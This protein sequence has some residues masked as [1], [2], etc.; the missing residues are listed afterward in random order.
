MNSLQT[1]FAP[2]RHRSWNLWRNPIFRRY[3]QSRLRVH[4]LSVTL[5]LTIL[6]AGFI[7]GMSH[8]I[9]VQQNERAEDLARG[10][11]I[12][13]LVV[14]GLILFV[15]GT[16]QVA[17]GMTA[18]RDE[19][20]ID[21]QRLVPMSPLAK[22]VGYLFGL[23]VREYVM[24]FTTLPFSA[25]LA[26]RGNI[27]METW[28]PLYTVFF[29][30]TLLYHFTGLLT[31]TVAKN[32]R[33]AFL[34]SIGLVF[35]L[36]TVVPYLSKFGLVFFKY[37]TIRPVFE[38]LLPGML[39]RD[40]G[41]MVEAGQRLVPTVKF[42][43]LDFSEMVF[44]V[45][46]QGGLI[47][48]FIV[49]LCRKW[50]RHES[51]LLGKL[52]AAGFFIW[53]QVLL[54]GNAL[55]LIDPGTLFPTREFTR[56]ARMLLTW[57]PKPE[58]ALA[59]SALYGLATM[60]LLFILAAIISPTPESQIRGWRRARKQGNRSLPMLSDA[61]T[62]FWSVAVMALAGAGGWYLFSRGLV[63]SRWFDGHVLPLSVFGYF[64]AILLAAGLG[65]QIL[66]ETKGGRAVVLAAIFVGVV[67]MMIGAL[68]AAMGSKL[69]PVATWFIGMSP[70]SMPT[71]A[72]G[73]LLPMVE[74]PEQVVRAIPRA[75]K[76]WLFVSVIGALWLIVR[77]WTTRKAMAA[78]VLSAP[79]EQA[80]PTGP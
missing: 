46:S 43:G 37:L 4:G 74:L 20:V 79:A 34:A 33:W 1:S 32:R 52:W 16:A 73:S 26:W 40:V 68:L 17:G 77:L 42:F 62:G 29:T 10:A 13:M 21:Y 12:A 55:P 53:I 31:G 44:T 48:T 75:F 35:A 14:Q 9:A 76:F 72:A 70:L 24:F 63:E 71:Y 39:P 2:I 22:V 38:E 41:A 65:F 18:E 58:E 11:F 51:H 61:S 57:S 36:Y 7:A 27:A 49:M 30:S 19:G 6:V 60:L 78:D 5:L 54:L 3:C 80:P 67:P 23:P 66:L 15:L 45:F 59:M 47:I 69:L 64:A 56:Y 25:W 8:A 50:R 28:L